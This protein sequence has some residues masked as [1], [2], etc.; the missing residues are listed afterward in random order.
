MSNR[1]H[2][3]RTVR[4]LAIERGSVPSMN[5]VAERARLSKGGLMHHFNSRAALLEAIAMQAI[6][7][8]DQTLT[9]AAGSERQR[10]RDLAAPVILP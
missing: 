8:M 6:Q 4:R 7:D 1:E 5:V 3:L 2:I 9:A 10:G